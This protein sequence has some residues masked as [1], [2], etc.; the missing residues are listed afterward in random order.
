MKKGLKKNH[1]MIGALALMIAVAGYLNFHAG[2]ADQNTLASLSTEETVLYDL[3]EEDLAMA[4]EAEIDENTGEF[5]ASKDLLVSENLAAAEGDIES[6]DESEVIITKDYID[7]EMAE[8]M[9]EMEYYEG[10][11]IT[12]TAS[13]DTEAENSLTADSMTEQAEIETAN[14]EGIETAQLPEGEETAQTTNSTE[15]AQSAEEELTIDDIPGEAVFT[16]GNGI[17]SLASAR[18]LKEQTRAMNREA[19]LSVINSETADETSRQQ[20]TD[21]MLALN[22]QAEKETAAEI[23]LEAKGYSEVVV[24]LSEDSADVVVGMSSLTKEQCAQI[25]DAVARKTDIPAENIVITP[26]GAE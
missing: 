26:A 16:G 1:I 9:D 12:E 20:A 13:K 17:T 15:M 11:A 22:K 7:E 19:L 3:S 21:G 18:L 25:I 4:E 23:L 10:S 24:S 6:L 2:K 8:L 14:G 5:T